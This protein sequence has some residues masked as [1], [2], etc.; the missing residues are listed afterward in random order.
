MNVQSILQAIRALDVLVIGDLC[1]DRWCY[2]DPSASEPSRE[3]GIP[4]TAVVRTENT[5]GAAGTICNNLVAL[6]ARNVSV[7]SVVGQ[8]GFGSELLQALQH[9][10]IEGN[11]LVQSP[12]VP[13]FTYTKLINRQTGIEDLGRIDFILN[14]PLPPPV[15]A[16]ILRALPA[17]FERFKV[18]LVSDQA[19][20]ESGGVI[21][22]AVR[23]EIVSLA[24]LHQNSV[25]W[26][27]SRVR[28]ELFRHVVLKP[29]HLEAEAACTR[30]YGIP[31][32]HR[33][34]RQNELRALI[35]TRGESGADVY[36][37]GRFNR[38]ETRRV[39]AVDICGAGDSFSAGGACALAVTGSALQ[40]AEFEISLPQS[41]SP[42]PVPAP[43]PRRKCW[44]RLTYENACHRHWRNQIHDGR[45]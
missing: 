10:G 6:G 22:A 36:Q 17:A 15:E 31:N 27:D 34:V 43:P 23:A 14:S 4:R 41:R 38:I 2:Y 25:V 9:R 21:T 44:K 29:N 24:K 40:A 5:P 13:T 12:S 28:P 18:I 35:V 11:L 42:N 1:L 33:L 8:D 20:T 32:Y 39:S 7:L 3:T 37:D 30:L 19:E 16:T 26:V 45:L